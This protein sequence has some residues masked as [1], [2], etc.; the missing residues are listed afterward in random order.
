MKKIKCSN[1]KEIIEDM[2]SSNF[3]Y[4]IPC[5]KEKQSE[6]SIIRSSLILERGKASDH[7]R[8]VLYFIRKV[9]M[10]NYD[11]SMM[12]INE[13]ITLYNYTFLSTFVSD[14]TS[15][16]QIKKMWDRLKRKS[17]TFKEY[18]EERKIIRLV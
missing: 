10:N 2:C 9:E 5:Y 8:R 16:F 3:Y 17:L 18:N 13:I 15:G 1:C 11:I 14:G 12:D 4:C 6:F 7:R